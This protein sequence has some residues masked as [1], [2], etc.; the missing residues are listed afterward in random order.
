METKSVQTS[1]LHTAEHREKVTSPDLKL[2]ELSAS[3]Q[4]TNATLH[5]NKPKGFRF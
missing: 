2:K 1:Q 4:L 5:V 3:Y